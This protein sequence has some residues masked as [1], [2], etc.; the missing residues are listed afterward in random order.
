LIWLLRSLPDCNV[1]V[2]CLP[3]AETCPY[4][5][6]VIRYMVRSATQFI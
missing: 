2:G 5:I 1:F 3:S 6:N 4:T